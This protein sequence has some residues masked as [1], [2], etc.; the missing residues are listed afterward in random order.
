MIFV[1][2]MMKKFPQKTVSLNLNVVKNLIPMSVDDQTLNKY[3]PSKQAT[4]FTDLW[5]VLKMQSVYNV[6]IVL[7]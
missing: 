2:N 6:N 1:E 7:I 3:L 5:E 4:L